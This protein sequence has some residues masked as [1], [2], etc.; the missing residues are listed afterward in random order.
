MKFVDLVSYSYEQGKRVLNGR[1]NDSLKEHGQFLTHP[2]VAR[3]MAK[4]LG[5]IQN[6]AF[7]L[8]PAI[9][10]G[11]LVCAVIERLIA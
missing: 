6:G 10:S 9:G 8:E 5:Q 3:Y 11:V 7:L 2:S 1:G 4:E